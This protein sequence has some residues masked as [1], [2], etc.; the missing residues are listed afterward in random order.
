MTR[1]RFRMELECDGGQ[2]G[3]LAPA[4]SEPKASGVDG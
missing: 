2:P 3:P 1:C 4:R